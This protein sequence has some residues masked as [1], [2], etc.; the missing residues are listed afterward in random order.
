MSKRVKIETRS[1][2]RWIAAVPHSEERWTGEIEE[3]FVGECYSYRW[4][5]F[6]SGWTT[7]CQFPHVVYP[8]P[9]E[10]LEA[11]REKFTADPP[12]ISL[13]DADALEDRQ[14][15]VRFGSAIGLAII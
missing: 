14:F 15:K 6:A 13:R 11:A 4:I 7:S 1:G 2:P 12:C 3:G 8:T 9:A 10:A 5:K